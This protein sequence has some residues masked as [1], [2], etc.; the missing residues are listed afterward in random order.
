MIA[1]LCRAHLG[2]GQPL[3]QSE[4]ERRDQPDPGESEIQARMAISDGRM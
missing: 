2:P 4:T 3:E 1:R